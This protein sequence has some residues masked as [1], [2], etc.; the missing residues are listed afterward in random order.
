MLG[1]ELNPYES[2]HVPTESPTNA[3]L[4]RIGCLI[5]FAVGGM[6][7]LSIFVDAIFTML[8]PAEEPAREPHFAPIPVNERTK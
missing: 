8:F 6:F 3:L 4:P 7:V 1:M 2:P 5:L